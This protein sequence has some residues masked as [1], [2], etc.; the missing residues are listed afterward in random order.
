MREHA[1]WAIQ[2]NRMREDRTILIIEDD[3]SDA[4][5]IARMLEQS[6]ELNAGTRV[7]SRLSEAELEAE[8]H[9]IGVV[10]AD[11]ALPDSQG[12][13]TAAA[14]VQAFPRIPVVILTGS[15]DE[16]ELT[17]RIL[18]MGVQDYLVKGE[19]DARLLGRVVRHSIERAKL[20]NTIRD[21]AVRDPLTGLYNRRGLELF[22]HKGLTLAFREGLNAAVLYGDI[23]NLKTVNDQ[24]GH[25]AGDRHIQAVGKALERSFRQ[26]DLV[27]RIGGDEFVTVLFMREAWTL[28]EIQ[29]R[30]DEQLQVAARNLPEVPSIS[31]GMV[32]IE[33][34]AFD[35]DRYLELAD[36]VMYR[37]KEERRASAGQPGTPDS[38]AE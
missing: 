38:A 1:N 22:A 14:L 27:A 32:P 34:G 2:N 10:I 16:P 20:L 24:L 17:G 36:E 12:L 8:E 30:V 25:A 31:L 7:C 19:F 15:Q 35:V 21:E 13:D 26:G 23:N 29:D 5:L 9:E 11:L 33:G 18:R 37:R 3:A 6:G 4:R 28:E